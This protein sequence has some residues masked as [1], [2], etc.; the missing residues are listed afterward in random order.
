MVERTGTCA[1]AIQGPVKD[2]QDCRNRK[3]H[4]ISDTG[5]KRI[6]FGISI[7][8]RDTS[9]T[10][11]HASVGELSHKKTT[12]LLSPIA[13]ENQARTIKDDGLAQIRG[14]RCQYHKETK[15]RKPR[16]SFRPEG[17]MILL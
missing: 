1:P 7:W 11:G 5:K 15:S 17:D 2:G 14:A 13:T 8:S 12:I 10:I 6:P 4:I 9:D 3:V 16:D